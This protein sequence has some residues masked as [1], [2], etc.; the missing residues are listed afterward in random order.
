MPYNNARH[1]LKTRRDEIEKE[2]VHADNAPHCQSCEV[3]KRQCG[4]QREE[5]GQLENVR[6]INEQPGK[7]PPVH[8]DIRLML[9]QRFQCK[10][11]MESPCQSDKEHPNR[12]TRQC[13]HAKTDD[14]RDDDHDE[15][16]ERKEI[17]RKGYENIRL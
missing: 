1:R 5:N 2:A 10:E 4:R 3:G 15:R 11:K 16:I 14:K 9:G 13:P 12:Q 6:Q 8:F 17:R 7:E